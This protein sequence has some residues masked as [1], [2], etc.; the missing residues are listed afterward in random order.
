[1]GGR[2]NNLEP[3]NEMFATDGLGREVRERREEGGLRAR[4]VPGW[5]QPPLNEVVDEV[6][7]LVLV[8]GEEGPV[9]AQGLVELALPAPDSEAAVVALIASRRHALSRRSLGAT[10]LGG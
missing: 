3:P 9:G 6:V 5:R 4:E 1:M 8:V 2:N 10:G 7:P